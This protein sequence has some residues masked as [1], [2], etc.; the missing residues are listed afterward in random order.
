MKT[1]AYAELD[2]GDDPAMKAL[3][4]EVL[5]RTKSDLEVL[6]EVMKERMQARYG[7]ARQRSEPS[8]AVAAPTPSD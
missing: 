1:A 5:Q 7:V 2:N 8:G 6:R 4:K 3:A